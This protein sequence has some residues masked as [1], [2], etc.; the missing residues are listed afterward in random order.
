MIA[1]PQWEIDASTKG[2]DD[3]RKIGILT[4]ALALVAIAGFAQTPTNAPVDLAEI[5]SPVAAEELELLEMMSGCTEEGQYRFFLAG[6]CYYGVK[7]KEQ[8]QCIN[9]QWVA[10]GESVC[11]YGPCP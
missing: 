10:T 8:Y 3:M 9:G 1:R 6:C 7:S 11:F 5:F 4:F 2:G